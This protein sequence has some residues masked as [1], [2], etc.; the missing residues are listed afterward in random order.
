MTPDDTSHCASREVQ[1]QVWEAFLLHIKSARPA[2]DGMVPV[3]LICLAS[4]ESTGDSVIDVDMN[5]QSGV[6]WLEGIP[7]DQHTAL[8]QK[9]AKKLAEK[10]VVR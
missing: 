6:L 8:L 7:A 5:G 3:A 10:E 4:I 1:E 2:L 9:V